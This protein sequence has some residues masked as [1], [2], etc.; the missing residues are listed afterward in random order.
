ML[1][2]NEISLEQMRI[3]LHIS[4]RKA[5]WMLQT[6][7]IPCRMRDTPTHKYAV[8]MEDVEAYLDRTYAERRDEIPVGLFNSN[9]HNRPHRNPETYI[10]VRGEEQDRYIEFLEVK[11]RKEPDR[12]TLDQTSEILGYAHKTVEKFIQEGTLFSLKVYGMHYIPKVQLIAFLASDRAF[13]IQ[14]KSEWHTKM[15]EKFLKE[16]ERIM[17]DCMKKTYYE[18]GG[19]IRKARQEARVSQEELARA[20]EISDSYISDIEAGKRNFSVD[21]LISIAET[22]HVSCD[23]LLRGTSA[24]LL[25]QNNTKRE[26]SAVLEGLTDDELHDILLLIT[27]LK[28]TIRRAKCLG[29]R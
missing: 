25:P 8:R 13:A 14:A 12:L 27:D 19:R 16:D 10:T 7:V 2:D 15:I 9:C 21:I 23:W 6:G 28:R 3:M 29:E 11:L 22:L 24:P 5:A 4:K 18:I 20:T 1:D 26:V 17:R